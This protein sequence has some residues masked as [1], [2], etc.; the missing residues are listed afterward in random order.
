MIKSVL[1]ANRGEIALRVARTCRELGLR[2]VAVYSD[3]D[4]DSAVVRFADSAVRIG[5]SPSKASYLRIPAI[6]EAARISG[7]DAIHPGY[8]FLSEDPD[9]AEVCAAEGLTFIGAPA[10][11]MAAL[12]D[13]ARARGI[14]LEAGLP[15]LPGSR[16]PIPDADEAAAFAAAIGYP[17]IVKAVAGGGGMGMAVVTDPAAFRAAFEKTG[18][19]AL[20]I[21]GDGRLYVERYLQAARHVEIQVLADTH[22]NVVHL[23]GRDCSLQRRQQKLV[24][25]SPVPGISP[26][27]AAELGAAAVRGALA[28]GYAGAGTFEFLLDPVRGEFYFMEVNCR[29]QVEHPVTEMVTGIDLVHEQIRI[30]AGEPLGYRQDDI[31]ARGAAIECRINAEDP[32]RGFQPTPGLLTQFEPPGGP[33]VR[34]DSHAR[35]GYEVPAHYDSLLAKV[36]VWAPDRAAAIAR[37]RR[38]LGELRAGGP[39]VTTTATFLAGLIDHPRFRAAEHDTAMVTSLFATEKAGK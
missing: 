37:M 34:V 23:G 29:L 16:D 25:E 11:V 22:G 24:E 6:I 18:A 15:L 12:G 7:A 38:A 3:A 35:P 31:A 30:A 17:V 39:S 2:T 20:A 27:Q 14:M 36:I 4:A 33:W 32:A 26:E 10:P 8:G 28:A 9:F 21:F 5:P 1:I 13:K 19:T